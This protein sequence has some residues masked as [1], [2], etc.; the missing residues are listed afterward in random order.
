MEVSVLWDVHLR[1]VPLYNCFYGDTEKYFVRLRKVFPETASAIRLQS[2][3][4]FYL[5][6]YKTVNIIF[7]RPNKNIYVLPVT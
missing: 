7:I 1:E 5:S 4:I 6:P 2:G 3:T